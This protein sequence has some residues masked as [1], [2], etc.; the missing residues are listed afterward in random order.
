MEE[1]KHLISV[2]VENRFGVLARIAGL[3]S[4][5]GFNI[6]FLSV[7]ETEDPTVSHITIGV[8]GN[9]RILEQISKQLNKLIDVIK[10]QDLT[11]FA[12][13]ERELILVKINAANRASIMKIVETFGSQVVDVGEKTVVVELV[14]DADRIEIMLKLLRPFGIKEI[15]RTGRVGI[16]KEEKNGGNDGKNLL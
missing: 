1:K 6:D 8:K 9:E 10:V 7:A 4:A 11:S 2:T 5:R 12:Y 16:R 14:G 15:R 3:F 13:L